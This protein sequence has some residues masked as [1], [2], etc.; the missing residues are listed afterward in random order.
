M[1]YNDGVAV[2]TKDQRGQHRGL[3]P[4]RR[5]LARRHRQTGIAGALVQFSRSDAA[6][7]QRYATDQLARL[8]GAAVIARQKQ[9][10]IKYRVGGR[11]SQ[12]WGHTG[13]AVAGIVKESDSF[14]SVW[15][16]ARELW[17]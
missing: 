13:Q 6:F 14:S 16:T 4:F 7:R 2:G 10:A 11:G 3:D 1:Q 15:R 17:R 9:Q 5:Q 8:D 12:V